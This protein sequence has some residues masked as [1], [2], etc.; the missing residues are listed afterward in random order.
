M[1][2]RRFLRK[3]IFL[4]NT[5][6]RSDSSDGNHWVGSTFKAFAVIATNNAGFLLELVPDPTDKS[7]QG[8]PLYDGFYHNF[9]VRPFN[10]VFENKTPQ[11][12]VWVDVIISTED[13][14]DLG[15]VRSI[16][17]SES[18]IVG[19]SIFDNNKYPVTSA[20]AQLLPAD[21]QRASA[22]IFNQTDEAFYVGTQ[23]RISASDF[24]ETCVK[25]KNGND[26]PFVWD[27]P[28]ALWCRKVEAAG[29]INP[30]ILVK[31]K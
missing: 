20:A 29:T 14:L 3:R 8:L 27:L 18:L 1:S 11:A 16:G 4:D 23:A 31:G 28:N 13:P 19:G 15:T 5:F 2:L 9:T 25:I 22:Q 17:G 24:A 7:V 21:D 6:T 26:V 12:G 10:G 30:V